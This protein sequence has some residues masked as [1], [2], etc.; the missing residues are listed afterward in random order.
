MGIGGLRH[1]SAALRP[2]KR[3]G[4]HLQEAGWT[5]RPVWTGA[6]NLEPTGIRSQN[7]PARSESL[8]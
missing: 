4:T 5:Q 8:Y 1:V 3:P 2:G 6:E 7:P